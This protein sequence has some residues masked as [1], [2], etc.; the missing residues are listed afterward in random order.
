MKTLK[1]LVAASAAVAMV[2]MASTANAADDVVNSKHNLT[3]T[4]NN[5]YTSSTNQVCVF[6]HTPHAASTTAQPLW[7]REA[8]TASYVMYNSTWSTTINM[9]V[10]GNPQ[11]VSLACL[12][13]H[14]GTVALDAFLNAP[15]SGGVN[16]TDGSQGYT[17]TGADAGNLFPAASAGMLGPDMR[18]DHP[19]SITY[20]PAADPAFNAASG[21]KV[22]TLPLYG[23]GSNQVECGSCHN[24][25]DA[26][27]GTFLRIS[28]ASSALCTTCH[29]K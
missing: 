7:N 29:Q 28:N 6:C 1:Y 15:G 11:G 25:H 19:I 21:G 23:T 12:S 10:A 18:N 2:G 4:T 17:F 14:D 16:A 8:S 24:P 13:C 26:S 27:N 3:L 22:G 9:T 5:V 20:D